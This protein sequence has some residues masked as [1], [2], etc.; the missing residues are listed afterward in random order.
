[1]VEKEKKGRYYK[2]KCSC[3]QVEYHF[4]SDALPKRVC[5]PCTN[6]K[7]YNEIKKFWHHTQEKRVNSKKLTDSISKEIDSFLRNNNISLPNLKQNPSVL[8]DNSNKIVG[9]KNNNSELKI[10]EKQVFM[11][12][13]SDENDEW[14]KNEFGIIDKNLNNLPLDYI[15]WFTDFR[16]YLTNFINIL[17]ITINYKDDASKMLFDILGNINSNQEDTQFAIFLKNFRVK[18][19][20]YFALSFLY[21]LINLKSINISQKSIASRVGENLSLLRE[22]IPKL[23]NYLRNIPEYNDVCRFVRPHL[24]SEEEFSKVVKYYI[25]KIYQILIKKKIIN[26]FLSNEDLSIKTIQII[27]SFRNNLEDIK[28]YKEFYEFLV[29][30]T[31]KIMA[32]VLCFF[33]LNF[34]ESYELEQKEYI[35][36]I[37]EDNELNINYSKF[38][39]L[40]T[41]L[42]N[43]C[44]IFKLDEYRKDVFDY[45]KKFLSKL[46]DF[47]EKNPTINKKTKILLSSKYEYII[48]KSKKIF[49][50]TID[51]GFQIIL[52]SENRQ[53]VTFYTPQ[54]SAI[55]LIHYIIKTIDHLQFLVSLENLEKI[56]G[57]KRNYK[58]IIESTN[59]LYA[60]LRKYLGRYKG[61]NY[62]REDFVNFLYSEVIN[63]F[64]METYF[65]LSLFTNT[66]LSPQMFASEIGYRGGRLFELIDAI[67]HRV[68]FIAPNT[69]N[70]L[71]LFIRTHIPPNKRAFF[72]KMLSELKSKRHRDFIYQNVRYDFHV[73]ISRVNSIS[74]SRLR[75]ALIKYFSLILEAKIP[76]AFFNLIPNPRASS[77]YFKG[78]VQNPLKSQIIEDNLLDTLIIKKEIAIFNNTYYLS[79]L[80]E[81]V[82]NL[83]KKS[84]TIPNHNPI[85]KNCFLNCSDILAIEAPI[86]KYV[87][88]NPLYIGH[89]DILL[90]CGNTIKIADYKVDYLDMLKSIPQI[91]VY[92]YM[93]EYVLS[94]IDPLLNPNIS[95][96]MFTK[97]EA[98]EFSPKILES[99]ILAFVNYVKKNYGFSL[100]LKSNKDL[101]VEIKKITQ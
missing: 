51:D 91:C 100:L 27:K 40:F 42:F 88:K 30:K 33:F 9:L 18:N 10:N 17:K 8:T 21:I 92:G 54:T 68:N 86:W 59:R 52:Y 38:S 13:K 65:L 83:Y 49:N 95:C 24:L 16:K 56:F 87:V 72:I 55:S 11:T 46:G 22:I 57:K 19:P 74:N 2:I 29:I 99:Y 25:K 96:V 37:N 60:Y 84:G 35:Q 20:K 73:D 44:Y 26:V 85:L 63:H 1:M 47:V 34:I 66:N 77:F 45:I 12:N 101:E 75:S 4:V 23:I 71:N 61:Q 50:S 48:E 39:E 81:R 31:P 69:Y 36:F 89:I 58:H 43:N 53:M 78:T 76:D 90:V 80:T 15:E 79:R 62:S 67:S 64:H 94:K 5:V 93:L 82:Y 7:K 14:V 3:G 70:M 97:E 28:T 41:Q 98:W 6:C 32:S